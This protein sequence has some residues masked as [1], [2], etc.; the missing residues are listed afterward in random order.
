MKNN[1]FLSIIILV[2]LLAFAGIVSMLSLLD[3]QAQ[4]DGGP[5]INQGLASH[6]NP[7]VLAESS[8]FSYC[9]FNKKEGLGA[10]DR[11]L[12]NNP[13]FRIQEIRTLHQPDYMQGV[14][15]SCGL[16]DGYTVTFW[17]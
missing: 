5:R 14:I 4:R 11:F 7:I 8:K 9:Y 13:D 6:Q 3:Y 15:K 1:R 12:A 2:A 10:V 17:K 16:T